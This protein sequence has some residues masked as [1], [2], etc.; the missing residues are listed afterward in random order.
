MAKAQSGSSKTETILKGTVP[1]G[2]TQTQTQDWS[3]AVCHSG[4][5]CLCSELSHDRRL[6]TVSLSSSV[7]HMCR[8]TAHQGPLQ[9]Y[10]TG[11]GLLAPISLC[12][13]S[14]LINAHGPGVLPP[15][16]YVRKQEPAQTQS[17]P[18]TLRTSLFPVSLRDT[19]RVMLSPVKTPGSSLLVFQLKRFIWLGQ[20]FYA[21][22]RK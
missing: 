6:V 18:R 19:S 4:A 15:P 2:R 8:N 13:P 11:N 9:L 10:R 16:L 21:L 12:P 17:N 5:V 20:N 1:P 7:S 3:L 14:T 22:C